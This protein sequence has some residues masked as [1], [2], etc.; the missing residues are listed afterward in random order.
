MSTGPGL[1][2]SSFDEILRQKY[3]THVDPMLSRRIM[4]EFELI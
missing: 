3:L 1:N 4:S 2:I